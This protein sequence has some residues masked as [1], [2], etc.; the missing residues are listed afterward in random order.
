M[1]LLKAK[2]WNDDF[3]S[4][5]SVIILN[6]KEKSFLDGISNLIEDGLKYRFKVYQNLTSSNEEKIKRGESLTYGYYQDKGL[7]VTIW[8]QNEKKEFCLKFER[9]DNLELWDFFL[10][11][12][13]FPIRFYH[14]S[15]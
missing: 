1:F 9:S 2:E 11:L 7:K 8:N 12:K 6:P 14:L 3:R 15:Y 5:Q 10:W 4:T 13:Y